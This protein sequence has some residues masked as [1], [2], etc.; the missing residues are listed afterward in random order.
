MFVDGVRRIDARIWIDDL[1]GGES[2]DASP[3][4]AG[5]CA[6]YAAGAVCACRRG[7]HLL[8]DAVRRGLFTAATTVDSR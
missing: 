8:A 1:A 4:V 7:A 6:S 3:A 5:I 2:A